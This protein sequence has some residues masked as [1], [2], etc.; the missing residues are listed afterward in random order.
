MHCSH[1]AYK[2]SQLSDKQQPQLH[3][4]IEVVEDKDKTGLKEQGHQLMHVSLAQAGEL[5]DN[6][7]SRTGSILMVS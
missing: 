2:C 3:M 7:A 5:P 6:Q 1:W 4:T